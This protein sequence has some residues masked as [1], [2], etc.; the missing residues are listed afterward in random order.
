MAL[1]RELNEVEGLTVILVTHDL[2]VARRARRALVL[3]DGEVVTDTT[4]FGQAAEV[5]HRRAADDAVTD[6]P[7]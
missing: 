7:A 2:E 3:V 6:S 4:D 5:L 1:F